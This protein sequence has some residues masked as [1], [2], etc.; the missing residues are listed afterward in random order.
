M[1]TNNS[2]ILWP[3]DKALSCEL[4]TFKYISFFFGKVHFYKEN[5]V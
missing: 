1:L 5:T 2:N 4:F 3:I